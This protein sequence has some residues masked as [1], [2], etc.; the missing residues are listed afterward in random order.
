MQGAFGNQK[1]S[2]TWSGRKIFTPSIRSLART[3]RIVVQGRC[4]VL[5][6]WPRT[7][8]GHVAIVFHAQGKRS[9]LLS[10]PMG[11]S[12]VLPRRA[13]MLPVLSRPIPSNLLPL[14]RLFPI[15]VGLEP[16]LFWSILTLF[17]SRYVPSLVC[18]N[19][20][21]CLLA[22]L[23]RL[24]IRKPFLP[25][26]G[27]FVSND[28]FRSIDVPRPHR[29]VKFQSFCEQQALADRAS[30]LFCFF[31]DLSLIAYRCRFGFLN[32]GRS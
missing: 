8:P 13:L 9:N 12:V 24:F 14:V 1:R 20:V 23:T 15:F 5:L 10:G 2:P 29:F 7:M 31:L 26:R 27:S 22:S 18:L 25:W 32:N 21:F 17:C 30:L 11:F 28:S 6:Y 3:S 19:R 4:N 16:D